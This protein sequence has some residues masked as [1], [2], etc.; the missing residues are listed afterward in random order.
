VD[1][2]RRRAGRPEQPAGAA[3]D[4]DRRENGMIGE[5]GGEVLRREL[6]ACLFPRDG[7]CRCSGTAT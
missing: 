2:Y 4:L 1:H 7:S 5:P 6:A 3:A